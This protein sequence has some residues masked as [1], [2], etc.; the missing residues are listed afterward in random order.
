MQ[1]KMSSFPTI[2]CTRKGETESPL[3]TKQVV[4]PAISQKEI[5]INT[6]L[7]V[8]KMNCVKQMHILLL[9]NLN[10]SSFLTQNTEQK[11]IYWSNVNESQIS[12]KAFV[13]KYN[14]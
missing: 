2:V 10:S 6:K 7:S 1:T 12:L 8:L 5:L 11:N 14:G 3:R 9:E 4:T 13:K